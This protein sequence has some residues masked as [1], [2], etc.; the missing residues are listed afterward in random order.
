MLSKWQSVIN[1]ELLRKCSALR[2]TGKI[3][4]GIARDSHRL[5][6]N[7]TL[8][9]C[10]HI[11][12]RRNISESDRHRRCRASV[13]RF[14]QYIQ[15]PWQPTEEHRILLSSW[16][17]SQNDLKWLEKFVF[18]L[19]DL[20]ERLPCFGEWF[21][22]T[23]IFAIE[24][25]RCWWKCPRYSLSASWIFDQSVRSPSIHNEKFGKSFAHPSN[26]RIQTLKW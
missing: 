13:Q 4:V 16:G 19:I 18:T 11:Q 12:C 1:Y 26:G 5:G 21:T 24:Q 6:A 22:K 20:G 10:S 9:L 3:V 8:M 15:I 2:Y 23:A 7:G 14:R 25:C 17:P